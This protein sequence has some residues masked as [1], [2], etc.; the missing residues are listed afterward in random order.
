MTDGM[1][2]LAWFAFDDLPPRLL[3][4]VMAL[5][6]QAF[7]LEQN[8]PYADMDGRDGDARH[9]V[10]VT[11]QPL[12]P[13]ACLRLFAPAAENDLA[14]RLGRI[15]VSPDYRKSGLGPALIREGL[16]QAARLYP[17][18]GVVISAQAALQGYYAAFGFSAEGAPYDEDGI[19]HV[20]MRAR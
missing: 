11:D 9:L 1:P 14:V 17:G 6:Q 19:P 12:R 2:R 15:V 20:T 4:G 7:V 5:R 18:V 16:A 13:A 8:C 10:A 3:Y